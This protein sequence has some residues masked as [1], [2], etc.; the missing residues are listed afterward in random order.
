MIEKMIQGRVEK[1]LAKYMP[2]AQTQ[3]EPLKIK[4]MV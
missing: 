3:A 2:Q 4:V 1:M